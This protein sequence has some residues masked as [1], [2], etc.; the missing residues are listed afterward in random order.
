MKYQK[1]SISTKRKTNDLLLGQT[2]YIVAFDARNCFNLPDLPITTISDGQTEIANCVPNLGSGPSIYPF[3]ET[4]R[5]SETGD[6]EHI[7]RLLD[8]R[9]GG[10]LDCPEGSTSAIQTI[11]SDTILPNTDT[12]TMTSIVIEGSE[13]CS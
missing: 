8:G 11:S 2:Q 4:Y 1:P 6:I 3:T 13:M 12:C 7:V 9:V 5:C 10:P